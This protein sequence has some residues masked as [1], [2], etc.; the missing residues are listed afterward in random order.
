MGA[1]YMY[2]CLYVCMYVY[3]RQQEH[4]SFIPCVRVC[5]RARVRVCVH[6]HLG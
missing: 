2:V 6:V 1:G 4:T 5:V 3:P